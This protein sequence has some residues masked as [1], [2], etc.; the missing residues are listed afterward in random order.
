[1]WYPNFSREHQ[2]LAILLYSVD[3]GTYWVYKKRLERLDHPDRC[4]V[5]FTS[6]CAV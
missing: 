5:T 3:L 6:L 1:M 4:P 2:V